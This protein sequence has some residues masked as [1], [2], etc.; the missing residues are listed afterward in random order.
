V[1]FVVRGGLLEEN[2]KRVRVGR[3]LTSYGF[4]FVGGG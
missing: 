1:L 2:V 4:Y 3:A